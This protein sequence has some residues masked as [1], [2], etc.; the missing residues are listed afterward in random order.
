MREAEEARLDRI[1]GET[2]RLNS[3][4]ATQAEAIEQE[5]EAKRTPLDAQRD[6]V[7]VSLEQAHL[8]C[9]TACKEVAIAYDPDTTTPE[10]VLTVQVAPQVVHADE[11]NLPWVIEDHKGVLPKPLMAFGSVLIGSMMGV[12]IAIMAKFIEDHGLTD[13]PWVLPG[14]AL[15]GTAAALF[16]GEGVK[17]SSRLATERYYQDKPWKAIASIAVAASAC[18]VAIDSK[19]ETEGLLQGIKQMELFKQMQQTASATPSEVAVSQYAW[20]APLL[21]FPYVLTQLADHASAW[22]PL[23]GQREAG[24]VAGARRGGTEGPPWNRRSRPPSRPPPMFVCCARSSSTS[25]RPSPRSIRSATSACAPAARRERRA[26]IDAEG[27]RRIEAAEKA[28]AEA[29]RQFEMLVAEAAS[30]RRA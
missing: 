5:R 27:K 22:T 23:G 21:S 18:I 24:R 7:N 10:M 16:A 6:A 8:A 4:A 30:P 12:S 13:R 29:E 9:K 1:N 11:Q 19:I 25:R 28:V 26:E 14:S 2:D 17:Q 15:T 3:T 20:A